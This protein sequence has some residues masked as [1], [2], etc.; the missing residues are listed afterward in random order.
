[1]KLVALFAPEH[2]IR[3]LADDKV[4]DSKGRRDRTS[5]LFRFTVRVAARSPNSSKTLDAL[6]YDI[7]DR[8]RALSTHTFRHLGYLLEECCEGKLPFI[9]LDRPIRSVVSTSMARSPTATNSRSRRT[10]RFRRGMV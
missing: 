4:S 5:D 2:G 7:Q 9:V 6:V 10:T 8:R 1:V 3:G